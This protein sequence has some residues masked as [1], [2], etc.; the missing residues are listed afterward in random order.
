[1]QEG[2]LHTSHG[3]APKSLYTGLCNPDTFSYK[4]NH[5]FFPLIK[6]LFIRKN[7]LV[8]GISSIRLA[9]VLQQVIIT[10]SISLF[11]SHCSLPAIFMDDYTGHN[12][13]YIHDITNSHYFDRN[14]DHTMSKGSSADDKCFFLL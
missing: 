3:V 7:C 13:E 4:I 9:V 6:L 8:Y 2:F 11:D 14:V 1:M 12:K 5:N 10:F